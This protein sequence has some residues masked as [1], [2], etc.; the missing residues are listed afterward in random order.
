[1][2]AILDSVSARKRRSRSGGSG[3]L[4]ESG[5]KALVPALFKL[6]NLGRQADASTAVVRSSDSGRSHSN[7]VAS[8]DLWRRD[9]R[10]DACSG[11]RAA[12]AAAAALILL[13]RF[14]SG[15]FVV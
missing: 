8:M 9:Q 5:A 10:I 3:D 14:G 12:T 13:H 7:R 2:V 11:D 4:L 15:A 1:L 6:G